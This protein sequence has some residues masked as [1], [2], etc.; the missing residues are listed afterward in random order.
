MVNELKVT[1][2]QV[3]RNK[4]SGGTPHKLLCDFVNTVLVPPVPGNVATNV[5]DATLASDAAIRA[6]VDAALAMVSAAT[7]DWTK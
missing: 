5:S 7:I 6:A 4:G 2:L 3:Q 1:R